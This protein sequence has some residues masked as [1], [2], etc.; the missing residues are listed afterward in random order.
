M[1]NA[2]GSRW[3]ILEREID[4]ETTAGDVLE[5]LASSYAEFRKTVFNPDTMRVS[6][7]VMVILNG[8]LLRSA[9]L[10]AVKLNDGDSIILLPVYSGG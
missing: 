6:N 1:L 3:L 7:Q 5:A 9:E 4:E 10:T 8:N 2:S